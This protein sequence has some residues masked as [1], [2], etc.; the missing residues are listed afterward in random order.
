M[1]FDRRYS[2]PSFTRRIPPPLSFLQAQKIA[3][4]TEIIDRAKEKLRLSEDEMS[5][6]NAAALRI[7]IQLEAK[8]ASNARLEEQAR[9]MREKLN[10]LNAEASK[11][12][13]AFIG[14]CETLEAEV[15]RLQ[16]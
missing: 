16:E 2:P 5:K 7:K 13:S 12:R 10:A 11:S 4:A 8:Q 6:S 1:L 9:T 14:E 3:A 15:I